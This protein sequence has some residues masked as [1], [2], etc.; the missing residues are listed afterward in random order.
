MSP[1]S[2]SCPALSSLAPPF[3]PFCFMWYSC[4]YSLSCLISCLCSYIC[5]WSWKQAFRTETRYILFAHTLLGDLIVLLL[6]DFVVLISYSDVQM[7]MV[8]CIPVCMLM[9]MVT[10]CTPMIITA[11]CVER[12]V[13]ICM[14]LR[15]SALSTSS[16]T[17]TAILTIWIISAV[18][19]LVD[20]II[21]VSTVSQAYLAQ[22]TFCYYE[23][24]TPEKWHSY[25]RSFLCII[26]FIII[27]LIEL[28]CYVMIMLA[29]RAASVD[30]KSAA[31]GLRTISLHM[32]Q[33]TLCTME[34]ICPYI[35][36]IV[37]Q[38]DIQDTNHPNVTLAQREQE[39]LEGNLLMRSAIP[40]DLRVEIMEGRNKGQVHMVSRLVTGKGQ[41]DPTPT[42]YGV[43][44]D[45]GV[46]MLGTNSQ[47]HCGAELSTN[48]PSHLPQEGYWDVS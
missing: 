33:L 12:Y 27:F 42:T 18:Y 47:I 32:L 17:H 13:A 2:G 9:D 40:A 4:S 29:A 6:T 45:G 28:F 31:K 36:A 10:I 34:I 46:R 1:S 22:L 19:P 37:I 23:I 43:Q 35:E 24:M 25:M 41:E 44:E 20:M 14:P 21:L 8:F 15:H 48:D 5:S 16:R 3:G 7:P 26:N 11:M 39:A 38:L 30:E